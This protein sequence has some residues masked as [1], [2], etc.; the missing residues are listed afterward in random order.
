[1]P[2]LL[3]GEDDPADEPLLQANARSV[4]AALAAGA[5]T[6]TAPDVTMAH[7]WHRSIYTGVRSVPGPHFLG[8]VRGSAHPDL[9]DYEVM[10]ADGHGRIVARTPLALE[11]PA[12]LNRFDR[13][14]KTSVAGLDMMV[15]AGTTPAD[16]AALDA[17]VTLCTVLHGE[18]VL[19]HPYANG[20]GRTARVWANWAAVRY[21]LPPF[22]RIKP[23]P[24][25]LL[26]PR[27][28][29][30]SMGRPPDFRGE[31]QLTFSLFIDLLRAHP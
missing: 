28:A 18:W 11:V 31:H 19:L 17:V 24:D 2:G 1:M 5:G 16:A 26:Y 6:R 29:A 27:A 3:W 14:L 23:R 22:V 9:L 10:I 13:S 25:G 15:P 4:L 12:R 8:G 21:G 20:N 7:A 30:S